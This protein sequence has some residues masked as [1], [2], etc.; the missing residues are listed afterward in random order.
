MKSK[1]RRRCTREK[2]CTPTSVFAAFL[3][4]RTIGGSEKRGGIF[5]T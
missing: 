4:Y 1:I 2:L 3:G 5:R